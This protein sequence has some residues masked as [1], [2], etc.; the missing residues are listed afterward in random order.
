MLLDNADGDAIM[1][2]PEINNSGRANHEAK[3]SFCFYSIMQYYRPR[4]PYPTVEAS[5]YLPP[6]NVS[7]LSRGR[8]PPPYRG[9]DMFPPGD[10][11]PRFPPG[12][13][14]YRTP[15]PVHP[16]QQP[17]PSMHPSSGPMYESPL[18]DSPIGYGMSDPMSAQSGGFHEKPKKD[19]PPAPPQLYCE[20]CKISCVGQA[21]LDAH[22]AGQKHKKRAVQQEV[23]APSQ[24]HLPQHGVDA[25]DSGPLQDFR[26]RNPVLPSQLQHSAEAAE[27]EVIHL[28]GLV[29]VDSSGLRS[30]K[31]C[32]QDDVLV[33][34]QVVVQALKRLGLEPGST[35]PGK[36]LS[37]LKCA[38]CDII[39]TGADTYQAHIIGKQHQRTLR[40]H[41]ALG[42]PVP[43]CEL[44]LKAST[45]PTATDDQKPVESELKEA[46]GAAVSEKKPVTPA[47]ENPPKTE[48]Q[49]ICDDCIELVTSGHGLSFRCQL[50]NC[51]FT[52][53]H[54]KD[55]HLKG[56]RH[57]TQ[58][59]KLH[60]PPPLPTPE[61]ARPQP[62]VRPPQLG[63]PPI[64]G[65]NGSAAIAWGPRLP[66]MNGSRPAG[67]GGGVGVGYN[68]GFFIPPYS[69]SFPSY[70]GPGG[71]IS[72]I[73]DL[74]YMHTKL[75]QV[76]PTDAE[77]EMIR[78]SVTACES[79]LK[80][81]N[82]AKKFAEEEQE[83]L[84][85]TAA[86][87]QKTESEGGEE[88][89]GEET[90]TTKPSPKKVMPP[91]PPFRGVFRV[92]ALATG[93]LLSGDRKADLV[94]VCNRWPT[95]DDIVEIGGELES[96]VKESR[97]QYVVTVSP[98]PEDGVLL[99]HFSEGASTKSVSTEKKDDDTQSHM[100]VS[101]RIFFTSFRALQL[102]GKTKQPQ[103][104]GGNFENED[105][106][107]DQEEEEEE[108][109]NTQ[110]KEDDEDEHLG[111]ALP[112][113]SSSSNGNNNC[114]PKKLC[115]DALTE[116]RRAVWL[117]VH[118]T[119][120]SCLHT[121]PFTHTLHSASTQK[122]VGCC[123][124]VSSPH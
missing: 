27:M 98:Q 87:E 19:A 59:R 34:L 104:A 62:W 24:F 49:E 83:A 117:Q 18:P 84:S 102:A 46:S 6:P 118:L 75:R 85:A 25:E 20:L 55:L 3:T 22:M 5:D 96:L 60:A 107:G 65:L 56:K 72:S 28:P 79:A 37:E 63:P 112:C 114:L 2:L 47:S 35:G 58:L 123:E 48:E 76:M 7:P 39:C 119:A 13:P 74:R 11:Y 12:G 88:K 61:R 1:P 4:Q 16:S 23:T 33:N 101:L 108:K 64:P 26:F 103:E 66:K 111:E 124:L 57:Q 105:G 21:C 95:T 113:S 50:C 42:K 110:K 36:L 8:A 115:I 82:D 90:T 89:Q 77:T 109:E 53:L 30:L 100:S 31:E 69:F 81:I 52:D 51:F 43:E 68:E 70:F 120:H 91:T 121:L 45:S 38:L 116:V 71:H 94:L 15:S 97:K 9:P 106:A 86:K 40:L 32:R 80:Q 54:A 29:R 44:P 122:D 92:G 41:K 93:L 14:I 17:H 78:L 67:V 73:G 99:V 10:S